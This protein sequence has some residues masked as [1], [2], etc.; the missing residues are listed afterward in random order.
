MKDKKKKNKKKK[1][2]FDKPLTPESSFKVGQ[3]VARDS[4]EGKHKVTEYV[5]IDEI[6]KVLANGKLL[7]R[8]KHGPYTEYCSN[9]GIR[10]LTK[11]E[12]GK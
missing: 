3:V 10:K 5:K 11:A 6:A 2:W 8:F 1:N 12:W 7:Y 4:V 9:K